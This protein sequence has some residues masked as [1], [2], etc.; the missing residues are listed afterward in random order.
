MSKRQDSR[1]IWFEG[2]VSPRSYRSLFKW[3]APD[4]YK[5]PN[6]RL[7]TVL[8]ER[9][10]IDVFEALDAA[11]LGLDE[12]NDV[13]P[14]ALPAQHVKA[15]QDIVGQD[16]VKVDGYTRLRATYGQAAIDVLRLREKRVDVIS[17]LVVL[18]RHKE[19]VRQVVA[20]CHQHR[21]PLYVISGRTSVTRGFEPAKGGIS[22]DLTRHMNRILHLDEVNQTVTVQPGIS[23]PAL[24]YALNNAPQ[25]F[26]AK[27]PY[28][29][30]HFPQSFEFSTV[31]G[32][33]V[34]RG[35]GQNSTYYGKI[36]DLVI[37]QE[38]VTPAGVI[39]TDDYPRQAT[40]PDIDQLLLGSE[41]SFGVLVE[42]TLKLYRYMP[43]NRKYFSFM[44]RDWDDAVVAA[45]EIMQAEAGHPSVFRISDAEETDIA[46]R[47]YGVDQTP[48]DKLLDWLGYKPERR[49]LMLGWTDGERGFSGNLR[50]KISQICRSQGGFPLEAF[51]VTKRWEKGR[52]R[53]PYLRDDL[54]DI[55]VVIDTLECSVTWA[56][57]NEV[58]QGVR[59]VV[60]AYPNTVCMTHVSH[61]YPQGANL[62][63]IFITRYQGIN[64]YLQMQYSILDAIVQNGGSVSHHHGV[65][66]H[67]APW[68]PD[69]VGEQHM[70]LLRHLKAFFDPDGVMNP[71][72][73]LGLDMS[74]EQRQKRWGLSGGDHVASG[75]A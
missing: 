1:K 4:E 2:D 18:P 11:H 28:T 29:C 32:W 42:V 53:D 65:G 31:G 36:E 9:L 75:V 35:A 55:G 34:T 5:H 17:D 72:G 56:R 48:A 26:G 69:Q 39:K 63:F 16:N 6:E 10:G 59:Q 62:Y 38:Y 61:A 30:G 68:L 21:I 47:L 23:G 14:C 24:E 50:R 70:A 60:K 37:S 22:L 15:M 7:V 25:V 49:C 20:Y 67:L 57:L 73:T 3:G 8:R 12:V 46:L 54:F 64:A 41:G 71:G 58:H 51:G 13:P 45:R 52:F 33:V 74:E 66:K 43:E 27:Y 19:H 44:F 40:G